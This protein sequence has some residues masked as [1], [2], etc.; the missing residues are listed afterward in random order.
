ML[1]GRLHR[2]LEPNALD[3]DRDGASDELIRW[4]QRSKE[5]WPDSSA[6]HQPQTSLL[7]YLHP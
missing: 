2:L 3:S 1:A 7:I 6:L 4:R 5:W